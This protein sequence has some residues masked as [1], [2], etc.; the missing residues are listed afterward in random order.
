MSSDD[1]MKNKLRERMKKFLAKNDGS[2]FPIT[3][4]EAILLLKLI[5]EMEEES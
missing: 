2:G 4:E 1:E 5:A 3:P